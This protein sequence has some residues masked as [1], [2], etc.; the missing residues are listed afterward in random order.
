MADDWYAL[1][2]CGL[3]DGQSVFG[4][5][6]DPIA[7]LRTFPHLF[8]EKTC[9]RAAPHHERRDQVKIAPAREHLRAAHKKSQQH[10]A[11]QRE[12]KVDHKHTARVGERAKLKANAIKKGSRYD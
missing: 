8:D 9:F 4:Y 1:K 3:G 7:K 11:P 12:Q 5:S 10:I 6:D 2:R